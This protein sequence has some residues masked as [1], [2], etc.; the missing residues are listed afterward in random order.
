MDFNDYKNSYVKTI[1]NSLQFSGKEHDFFIKIKAEFLQ[2]I[3]KQN[4]PDVAEP[5]LLDIGCG[6]GL[7][8]KHL[9]DASLNIV[10]V[11]MADEVLQLAKQSNPEVSYFNH[12][13]KVLPFASQQFDVAI[14]ICVMH[15]VPHI[16]WLSFLQEMK[17]VVKPGGI[18]IIFEH[19]PYNPVTRYIVANNVMDK[20][21][22]LLSSLK[23]KK[24]MH[25]AGFGAVEC[26]NILFT[27]FAHGIFRWL[28]KVL[29]RLPFGAQYYSIGRV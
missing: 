10:G 17:R 12:D 23:L 11:E 22:V 29:G 9:K 28:D 16:E 26:R 2:D 19:N 8:H 4:L 5:Y 13:G 6:H 27:P 25:V 3:I 7:I 20:D 24:L 18:A 15:H 14:T 21:A 1:E